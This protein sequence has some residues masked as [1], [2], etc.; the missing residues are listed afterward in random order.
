MLKVYP[1]TV[2]IYRRS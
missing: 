2:N 1:K